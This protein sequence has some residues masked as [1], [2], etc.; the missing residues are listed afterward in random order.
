MNSQLS[1]AQVLSCLRD[2]KALQLSWKLAHLSLKDINA[3]TLR[4]QVS[5]LEKAAGAEYSSPCS[6]CLSRDLCKGYGVSLLHSL[7]WLLICLRWIL[8]MCI[9]IPSSVIWEMTSAS[10]VFPRQLS[11][12]PFCAKMLSNPEK[13]R[14]QLTV[15]LVWDCSSCPIIQPG[16]NKCQCFSASWKANDLCNICSDVS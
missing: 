9:N 6:A 15:R 5:A 10:F 14:P 2:G 16:F 3:L 12:Q 13:G 11:W 4:N 1:H 8:E 7:P